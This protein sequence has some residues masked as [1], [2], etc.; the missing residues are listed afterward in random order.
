MDQIECAK[1]VADPIQHIAANLCWMELPSQ[2]QLEVGM[3]PS[4]GYY[5]VGRFGALG[6]FKRGRGFEPYL[7][8]GA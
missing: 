6:G 4:I 1:A 3:E 2:P 5:A 8:C 7:F